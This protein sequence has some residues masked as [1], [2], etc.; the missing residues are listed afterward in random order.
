MHN[1]F[2]VFVSGSARLIE[3]RNEFGVSLVGV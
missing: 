1:D 2:M 3:R